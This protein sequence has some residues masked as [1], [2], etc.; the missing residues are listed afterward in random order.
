VKK[1]AGKA[2]PKPVQQQPAKKQ[3][4]DSSDIE[5]ALYDGMQD[6][7]AKKPGSA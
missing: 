6:L 1:K 4:E 3:R 7:R 5:R 2:K